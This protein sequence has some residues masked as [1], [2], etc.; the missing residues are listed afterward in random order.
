MVCANLCFAQ[1]PHG[2]D[3]LSDGK[4]SFEVSVDR[5][6][7]AVHVYSL[8]KSRRLPS[9]LNLTL[10]RDAETGDTIKLRAL[11]R[12]QNQVGPHYEGVI[13]GW[14]GSYVGLELRIDVGSKN[15]TVLRSVP[16]LPLDTSSK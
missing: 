13:T 15:V 14:G 3:V 9:F 11:D 2:G 4:Y 1:G 6:S 5:H 10:L 16:R 7:H 12:S 8:K